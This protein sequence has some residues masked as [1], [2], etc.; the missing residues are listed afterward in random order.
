MLSVLCT[1][2]ILSLIH[3]SEVKIQKKDRRAMFEI[4]D[5]KQKV[6]QSE[7]NIVLSNREMKYLK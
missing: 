3:P 5:M 4:A 1:E 2:Q 6:A 7:K